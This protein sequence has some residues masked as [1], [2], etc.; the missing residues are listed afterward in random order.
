MLAIALALATATT[1]VSVAAGAVPSGPWQTTEPF[2]PHYPTRRLTVLTGTWATGTYAGDVTKATYAA[3][4]AGTPN[5]TFVPS[6]FDVAPAA[7]SGPRGTVFYRSVHACTPG[8]SA[9]IRFYAVNFFARV[10]F[11]GV[12]QANHTAGPYTPF[13]RVS[14]SCGASGTRE[15]ALMVNNEFD[16][17]LSP[18][19]FSAYVNKSY[20][21]VMRRMKGSCDRRSRKL[22]HCC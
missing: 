21:G 9:L 8:K 15:I 5:T 6:S 14:G 2:Y 17:T 3:L 22:L 7:I 12:E 19:S 20:E 11:D 4:V 16:K 13:S 10:F 18:V 1:C